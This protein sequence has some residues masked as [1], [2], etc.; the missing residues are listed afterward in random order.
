MT[1][2]LL[3]Y[4]WFPDELRPNARVDKY[5]KNRIFQQYKQHGTLG[6]SRIKMDD[7]KNIALTMLFYPPDN[8][9]RDLDNMLASCKALLDGIAQGMG[10]DDRAFRPITIDV[11]DVFKP[12][13]KIEVIL[14]Y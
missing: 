7:S 2:V 13:G 3:T 8:R 11:M 10:I 12:N 5:K 14:T 1:D 4:D 9:R 6:S